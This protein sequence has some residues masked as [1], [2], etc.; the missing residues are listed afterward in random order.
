MSVAPFMLGYHT[1]VAAP[2]VGGWKELARTTLGSANASIDVTSLA[3][4]RYYQVLCDLRYTASLVPWLRLNSVS[5]GDPYADRFSDNGGVDSTTASQNQIL[6]NPAST[7]PTFSNSYAGN[8]SSK[9]K[10]IT[11]HTVEQNTAGAATAPDRREM[12]AKHAQTSN[13]ISAFNLAA[14]TSTF[15]TGSEM[16]V[17]GWDPDD[18]HTDN[19]WEEL[20]T[21]T[22]T[23]TDANV[24]LSVTAKKYLWIQAYMKP[25]ATL[26]PWLRFNNVSTGTPYAYRKSDN[27]EADPAASVS[28][29]QMVIGLSESTPQFV[30]IFVINVSANEKLVISDLGGQNT[31]GKTNAPTRRETIAKHALTGSQIT[32]VDFV[33]STSTFASGS[34][35]KV[36]GAN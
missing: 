26:V 2:P 8:L 10:M 15:A 5:T 19:F 9:E 35:F 22:L 16:V 25:T 11:S 33:A 20:A 12:V 21:D 3:D 27:G 1:A 32:E 23:G 34:E 17:L 29:N 28:Q 7:T 31:A 13:P 18:T 24:Q 4:K 14:S 36:Y 6:L 30:N